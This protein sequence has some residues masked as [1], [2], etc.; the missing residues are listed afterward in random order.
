M[1]LYFRHQGDCVVVLVVVTRIPMI[2]CMLTVA[3]IS[4]DV[5]SIGSLAIVLVYGLVCTILQIPFTTCEQES[6]LC[7]FSTSTASPHLSR[8]FP[9]DSL[10]FAYGFRGSFLYSS[11]KNPADQQ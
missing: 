10:C 8:Y 3:I 7:F 1:K 2:P 4:E 5:G 6:F 9:L 11:A